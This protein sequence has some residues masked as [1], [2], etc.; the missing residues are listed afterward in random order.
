MAQKNQDTTQ[1]TVKRQFEG[2][3]VGVSEDKTARVEVERIV[4]HPKYQKQYTTQKVYPIHD[5]KNELSIGDEVLFEECRPLSKHK[6]W[7][8]IE[9]INKA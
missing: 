3:V 2:V 4:M 1:T 7:R 5:E 8:L 6:R 9:V